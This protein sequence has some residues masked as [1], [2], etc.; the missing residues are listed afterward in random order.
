MQATAGGVLLK[1]SVSMSPGRFR[2]G[3]AARS[4]LAHDELT[5]VL[6]PHQHKAIDGASSD[7][8]L[9]LSLPSLPSAP[10]GGDSP[11]PVVPMTHSP[12]LLGV[13]TAS[14]QQLQLG[15]ST[16]QARD[17]VER[18][19]LRQL[20]HPDHDSDGANSP[21]SHTNEQQQQQQQQ[22]R[23]H[24]NHASNERL[25]GRHASDALL[26]E[27][28]AFLHESHPS[29]HSRGGVPTHAA[30]AP[31]VPAP[32]Q[33]G[34]TQHGTALPPQA[35]L[36]HMADA[37]ARMR[38]QL[39]P[40]LSPLLPTRSLTPPALAH[41][42]MHTTAPLLGGRTLTAGAQPAYSSA[43]MFSS[44]H[45]NLP[46][47]TWQEHCLDYERLR[48]H[49]HKVIH[50]E[51]QVLRRE[52]SGAP[53][54]PS[55]GGPS[56]SPSHVS[57]EHLGRAQGMFWCIVSSE[58]DKV[59]NFVVE[60]EQLVSRS[61]QEWL[62][63]CRKQHEQ[64]QAQMA[65]HHFHPTRAGANSDNSADSAP[66]LVTQLPVQQGNSSDDTRADSGESNSTRPPT[67]SPASE[68]ST[69]SDGTSASLM[70][71]MAGSLPVS[72]D[73]SSD[74]QAGRIAQPPLKRV[75]RQS[76]DDTPSPRVETPTTPASL[77]RCFT[78][79][80]SQLQAQSGSANGGSDSPSHTVA[81]SKEAENYHPSDLLLCRKF[82]SIAT[83]SDYLRQ[84]V[85]L[86][87]TLLWRLLRKYAV[88]TH[89]NHT[90]THLWN[91]LLVGG[92]QHAIFPAKVR[93]I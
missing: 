16:Q 11:P 80:L 2:G 31:T 64:Q 37:H 70:S 38:A 69:N 76:D 59:V 85:F 42:H 44:L 29:K 58:W 60:Q 3:A 25:P 71:A 12:P 67:T 19:R 55:G 73:N 36:Q 92:A 82:L 52:A 43:G 9:P 45:A 8:S 40:G 72:T 79:L 20:G 7:D 1:Q 74:E 47:H 87:Y 14:Q 51:Q 62:E 28:Y 49:A 65:V 77:A 4:A 46:N 33:D 90:I 6:P 5:P 34:W 10:A 18:A 88:H 68:S 61:L 48:N 53:T 15:L 13:S 41:V 24:P 81:S 75:K 26:R 66:T 22:R 56:A 27:A 21:H 17:D 89:R 57:V 83:L 39:P 54:T 50:L 78:Y 30:P 86:N 84:F 63:L 35:P 93:P 32:P 23:S 91:E